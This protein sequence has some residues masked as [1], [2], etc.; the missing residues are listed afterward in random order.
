[1]GQPSRK[2]RDFVT[3]LARGLQVLQCFSIEHTELGTTEIARLT[4]LAQSTVWRL[5]HTLLEA[6]FLV[7]GNHPERLRA[8]AN[9]LTLGAGSVL[10]AG[11]AAA[12]HPHMLKLAE[13]FDAH[14]SLA[15]RAG[16]QMVIVQ[17]TEAPH[18]LQPNF[19]VGTMLP[20]ERSAVGAAYL[21]AI[22]ATEREELMRQLEQRL[23]AAAWATAR[24][25]LDE[26]LASWRAHGF[27]LNLGQL[28]PEINAVA[29]PIVA[30][31][32]RI[33][34]ALNCGGPRSS[35]SPA[36]LKGPVADALLEVAERLRM[37]L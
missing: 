26:G 34:M 15:A 22:I 16:A 10:H 24:K 1:M 3:A 37:L 29:A 25:F 14:L 13:Q 28:R 19:T 30:P 31:D 12:A 17:R 23:S 4:G 27:V 5:C 9:V 36:H 7:P 6:G 20:M 8:G 11:I 2:D 35:M 21:A 18:H 32:G 33:V